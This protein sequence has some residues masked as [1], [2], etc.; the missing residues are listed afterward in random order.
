MKSEWLIFAENDSLIV[1]CNGWGMDTAPFKP[2]S[3][4]NYDV[5]V[6]SDYTAELKDNNIEKLA[7]I[8][9]DIH[10]IGWSMGVYYGQRYFSELAEVFSQ[11]I[12][13]NG[14]LR[15]IDDH[16][17]IPEGRFRGTMEALDE[18]NLL[19]FYRRMCRNNDVFEQFMRNRPERTIDDLR[20]EL[21][22]ILNDPS[23]ML[24]QD[25]LYSKVFISRQD[26][27][28][29]T[30]NQKKYWQDGK[31]YFLPGGHFPFY[32]WQSW[33]QMVAEQFQH[34]ALPA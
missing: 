1:F 15:P 18:Q 7:H 8:Y 3:S 22:C 17:G 28:F 4:K 20:D 13:I 23:T 6:F 30:E 29:P 10:L 32:R 2:L 16:Y 26:L 12:A 14:T 5:L 34:T 25:S 27:V 21:R 9:R 31:F 24:K 33:D 19:K 11:T